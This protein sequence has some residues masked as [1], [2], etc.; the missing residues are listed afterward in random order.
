MSLYYTKMSRPLNV[1]FRTGSLLSKLTI[2][3]PT[4]ERPSYALRN[5]GF[6][7][8]SEVTVHILDGSSQ[9]MPAEQRSGFEANIHYHH[10]PIPL[11]ERLSVACDYV[12]TDYVALLGDDDFFLPSGLESCL[13]EL[14]IDCS[15]VSC[16]GRC[17]AFKLSG[18]TVVGWPAY[19]EMTGY[20]INQEEPKERMVAHMSSYTCS[21]IYSVVRAAV[22]KHAVSILGRR[23]FL[24]F[25]MVEFQ[26]EM[27]VAFLGKSRVIPVAM[28]LRS[29]ENE[30][31]G[32]GGDAIRVRA[33][34]KL[35]DRRADREEFFRIMGEA[36]SFN[37]GMMYDFIVSGIKKACDAYVDC[38]YR[39]ERGTLLEQ[40][41]TA[42]KRLK[43]AV[44]KRIPERIKK[45][46]RS[47]VFF[48]RRAPASKVENSLLNAARDLQRSGV[49]TSLQEVTMV[50]ELVA[51]FHTT[52]QK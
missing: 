37:T 20:Q 46:L 49:Q 6:W 4:Y 31:I 34:W 15:L 11:S 29:Q 22:W 1:K 48:Q 12:K 16:M 21:T 13:V 8:G 50:K 52:L 38:H 43:S 3:V 18:T 32:R 42:V 2:L 51:R 17:L 28:W 47:S 5:I 36:L 26:F 30:S 27:A 14:E 9:Q 44:G 23:R 40:S 35:A 25:A 7:S 24:V 39:R 19:T 41:R 45:I 33:W 10:L